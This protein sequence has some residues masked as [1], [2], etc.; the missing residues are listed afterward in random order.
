MYTWKKEKNYYVVLD[1]NGKFV[2]SADTVEE[3]KQDIE[4]LMKADSMKY[5]V[6]YLKSRARWITRNGKR[7]QV[8]I[9]DPTVCEHYVKATSIKEVFSKVRKCNDGHVITNIEIV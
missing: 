4:E 6:R 7:I 2:C 3:A 8:P 9:E 1:T 5:L